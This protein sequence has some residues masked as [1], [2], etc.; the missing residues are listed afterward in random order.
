MADST[1]SVRSGK[2]TKLAKPHPDFPLFLHQ[3][4]RWSKKVRGNLR[5]VGARRSVN[6]AGLACVAA[7]PEPIAAVQTSV[8]PPV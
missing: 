3:T 2:P 5:D 8:S 1:V 4:V 6:G 7:S